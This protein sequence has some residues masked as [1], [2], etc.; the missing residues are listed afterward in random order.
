[1]TYNRM[2]KPQ[3]QDAAKNSTTTT[4]AEPTGSQEPGGVRVNGYQQVVDMLEAADPAF[5]ESL[6]KR[7]TA[8]NPQLGASLRNRM[9]MLGHA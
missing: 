2:G 7:I 5:R 6:L 1:M 9:R 8:Q 3:S 4:T